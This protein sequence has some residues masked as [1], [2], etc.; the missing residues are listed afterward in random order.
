[1]AHLKINLMFLVPVYVSGSC[2]MA[3]CRPEFRVETISHVNKTIYNRVA[4]NCEY[5]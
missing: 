4:C 1:M 3:C 5:L 2:I